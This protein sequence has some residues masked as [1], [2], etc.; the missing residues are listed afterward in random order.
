SLYIPRGFAHGLQTLAAE[1]EVLYLMSEFY[2]SG[3]ERG[4]RPDDSA[5]NIEWPLPIS[6]ISERDSSWPDFLPGT[7]SSEQASTA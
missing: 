4:L 6:A 5:I 7:D 3:A 1:T 2:V